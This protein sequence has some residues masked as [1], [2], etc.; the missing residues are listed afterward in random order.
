MGV[1][2]KS[3]FPYL[4]PLA[5]CM[6]DKAEVH[7]IDT[8]ASTVIV[9]VSKTGVLSAFGHDHQI[10]APIAAGTVDTENRKVELRINSTALKVMDSEISQKDRAEIQSTMLGPQVLDAEQHRDIV[11]RSTA[12]EH[13]PDGSW[14]VTGD[15]TLHDQSKPVVVQVTEQGGKYVGVAHIRQADFGI[16]PVKVA[17]GTVRVKDEVRIEFTI[18]LAD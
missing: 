4:I 16:K 10:Q 3:I 1:S 12:A 6:A 8:A 14:R 15:L 17:G 7:R 18:Q 13:L 11:F 5:F 2:V 9:K